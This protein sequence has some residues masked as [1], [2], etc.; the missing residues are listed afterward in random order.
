MGLFNDAKNE[1]AGKNANVEEEDIF[2]VGEEDVVNAEDIDPE[3][4]ESI[5]EETAEEP[6]EEPK[7][8][9]EKPAAPANVPEVADRKKRDASD[10]DKGGVTVITKGTT[11][12]GSIISDCSLDVM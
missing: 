4:L 3:L 6:K 11:I 2:A 1:K 8:A 9:A 10:E 12:N 7:K 5:L